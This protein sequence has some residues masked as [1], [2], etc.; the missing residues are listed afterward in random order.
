[1]NVLAIDPSLTGFA[2]AIGVDGDV[3]VLQERKT[4]PAKVVTV[5]SRMQR[6]NQL[7]RAITYAAPLD[8]L[9]ERLVLIEGYSFGSQGRGIR[10]GAE[11]G[12]I[13]RYILAQRNPEL[14]RVIEVPPTV[15]KK[16]AAGKGNANKVA[17]ASALTSRY[18]REFASDNL[19]DAFGLLQL[20]MCLAGDAEAQTSFQR[21]AV[22]KVLPLWDE[23]RKETI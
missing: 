22:A 18:G 19:A 14:V 16:F 4:K 8:D 23:A 21:E 2:W 11:L 3:R 17:V 1:M 9:D 12:G 6:C 7:A 15:L 13:L 5:R 20:G 10:D